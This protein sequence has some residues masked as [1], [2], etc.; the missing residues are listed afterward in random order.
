MGEIDILCSLVEVYFPNFIVFLLL[1]SKQCK[2]KLGIAKQSICASHSSIQV[3]EVHFTA[4]LLSHLVHQFS[5]PFKN[6]VTTIITDE[7]FIPGT[8]AEFL[9]SLLCLIK[10]TYHL[11]T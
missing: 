3:D 2:L 10:I 1:I 9:A 11:S 7:T 6:P 4:I 8:K 5:I